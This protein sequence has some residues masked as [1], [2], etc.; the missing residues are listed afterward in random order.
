MTATAV[1][2]RLFLL[3]AQISSNENHISMLKST[4]VMWKAILL[5]LLSDDSRRLKTA[6]I[7]VRSLSK[8][9]RSLGCH[10]V[11]ATLSGHSKTHQKVASLNL[12]ISITT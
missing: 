10:N 11:L 1:S 3:V 2:P 7:S 12:G 6:I 5:E 8:H 9:F 4:K